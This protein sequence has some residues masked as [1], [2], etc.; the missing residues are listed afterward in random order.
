VG[1]PVCEVRSGKSPQLLTVRCANFPKP[2]KATMHM[3]A[4]N[5]TTTVSTATDS[6]R[7]DAQDQR[8]WQPTVLSRNTVSLWWDEVIIFP[9]MTS[10]RKERPCLIKSQ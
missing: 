2:A 8:E 9:C 10:G 6:E 4:F 3:A 1:H 7:C 5:A